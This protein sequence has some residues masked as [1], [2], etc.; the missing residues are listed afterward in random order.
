MIRNNSSFEGHSLLKGFPWVYPSDT[1]SP[2]ISSRGLNNVF[3]YSRMLIKGMGEYGK[4]DTFVF[5]EGVR[6]PMGVVVCFFL[7]FLV[8]RLYF[9]IVA[10]F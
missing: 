6:D 8:C 4:G 7:Q 5:F 10:N 9:S 2:D 3:N 1:S